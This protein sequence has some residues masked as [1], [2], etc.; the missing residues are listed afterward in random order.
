MKKIFEKYHKIVFALIT[1]LLLCPTLQKGYVMLLDWMVLPDIA[2][3]NINWSL[4]SIGVIIYK[5]LALILGF[6]TVQR[7]VL[8]SIVFFSGIAGFRLAK[9]TG[10]LTAQYFAGLFF[11]FNPF[12]Y[13][14]LIEQPINIASGSVL[15]LWFF[16]YFLEYLEGKSKKKLIFT[17][18]LAA[19]AISFAIYSVFFIGLSLVV[20][21]IFDYTKKKDWKF[22]LKTVIVIGAVVVLLNSNW[23]STF[24]AGDIRGV[25]GI[26]RFTS[27]DLEAFKTSG[28][29]DHSVYATVLA[30][31][32]YW[33]EDYDRFSSIQDNSLWSV[34]FLLI[35]SLVIMG[36]VKIWKKDRF[37]KPLVVIFLMAFVL[38]IGIASPI[39]KPLA[40]WLYQHVP[41]YIGLREPQKWVVV[42]VFVYAY[43]GGWGVK[44]LLEI[45]KIKN[46][47]TEIGIFCV[48]LP[49]IFSLSVIEGI[50]R[51]LTPHE[52]PS[53]WQSAKD[54][55]NQNPTDGKILFFPWHS[56]LELDF[57]GKNVIN[58]ARSFFGE[59][60]VQ[61]NN[62]EFGGVYSHSQDAQTMEIEKYIQTDGN[63]KKAIA[64]EE[65]ADDMKKMDM[66]FVI[67]LKAEDWQDY[68]WLDRIG[69]VKKVVENA[70]L[71][72]YK[73]Q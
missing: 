41:L 42:L 30:L 38:A 61:G 11:I 2:L 37:A 43:F 16:V 28:I 31:Q 54:Y 29:N 33:G 63:K 6:G 57:A 45:K 9:R 26:E 21:L 72:I 17:S 4:D 20:F 12:I 39:F 66:T 65:F 23:L 51:H 14:R 44:Y 18:I 71:I 50:H 62:T 68:Q 32:G 13:A 46:Y 73:L 69:G 55:L 25:G 24:F 7:I 67:L 22:C 27:D 60:V 70:K 58:P 1:L 3:S 56:Y 8:F 19:F 5:I 40:L 59:K 36:L 35:F 53:E 52:F 34:A 10:N 49:L 48:L 15:F 64:Y 47:K